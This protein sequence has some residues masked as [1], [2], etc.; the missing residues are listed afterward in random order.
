MINRN[1]GRIGLTGFTIGFLFSGVFFVYRYVNYDSTNPDPVLELMFMHP[2]EAII[3]SG[4]VYG[5]IL[6]VTFIIVFSFYN[7]I[8]SKNE[9]PKN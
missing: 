9:N 1:I 4:L 7:R 5:F 2:T 8:K 6:A 3:G